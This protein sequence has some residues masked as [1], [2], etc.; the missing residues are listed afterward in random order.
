MSIFVEKY[1]M[2]VCGSTIE[3][4]GVNKAQNMR[5][6]RK[7][8]YSFLSFSNIQYTFKKHL[9]RNVKKFLIFIQPLK[10]NISLLLA[11]VH[12]FKNVFHFQVVT[13]LFLMEAVKLNG[14]FEIAESFPIAFIKCTE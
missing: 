4:F 5:L 1:I 7:I 9:K 10:S 11:E 3:V 8:D 12:Y 13:Q 6:I 14:R 2:N